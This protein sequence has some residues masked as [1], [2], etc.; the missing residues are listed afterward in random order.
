MRIA[1]SGVIVTG[2]ASGL[3]LATARLLREAGATVGVVDRAGKGGW[4]GPFVLA[5]VSEEEQIR[6][7]FR[8]LAASGFA[9]RGV[10]H[11]AGGGQVGL[12]IGEGATLTVEGFRKT[13]A[14]N[15][16]GSFVV[17]KTAAELMLGNTPDADGERGVL[18]G[19]SS[20]VAQEGQI[21]TS[22]YAA[23]KGGVEA[24]ILPLAREFARF[25]IR[26]A[27]IAP[28][29]FETPMFARGAGPRSDWLRAQV[30]FPART[31]R[32][33]EFAAMARHILENGMLNGAT[34]R[35]DGAFR[36]PPGTAAM[37]NGQP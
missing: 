6:A 24:M 34:I 25:G 35:L 23:S 32:P 1:G 15:T 13:L 22:S 27:G 10:V 8:T 37:W 17:F 18:V 11:C 21:G 9:L 5:D 16:L 30:Q 33:E 28:G 29:I 31:G 7:A 20:I 14:I 2:G 3:G 12:C 19:V 4:D 36:V 26:V